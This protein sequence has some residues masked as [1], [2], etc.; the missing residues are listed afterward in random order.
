MN[1][2]RLVKATLFIPLLTGAFSSVLAHQRPAPTQFNH[3][4]QGA[5]I[6]LL[7]G[8]GGYK[9][10]GSKF[11]DSEKNGFM[12]VLNAGYQF[13]PNFALEVGLGYSAR[14]SGK[15]ILPISGDTDVYAKA[16]IGY[17][18]VSVKETIRLTS[19]GGSQ[20]FEKTKNTGAYLIGSIGAGASHWLNDRWA[21]TGEVNYL[22]NSIGSGDFSM[23]AVEAVAGA[24][25]HF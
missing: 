23:S 11:R 14:L 6:D 3:R 18:F 13:N 17:G 2:S 20:T 5:Y 12:S 9:I 16:G 24:S 19:S 7:A 10:S 4:I 1:Y 15:F 25:Y 21:I 22:T 8:Y